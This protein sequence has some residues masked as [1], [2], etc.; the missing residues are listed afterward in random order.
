M[1]NNKFYLYCNKC[2]FEIDQFKD[3][4]RKNQ[5]CP[6]CN[7]EYVSVKYINSKFNKDYFKK[8]NYDL[9]Y[10][11]LW[12]Y[13]D[14]LP[15]N[16]KA[17]IISCGEGEVSIDRWSFLEEYARIHYGIRCKV[18]A[19]RQDNNFATGTFKDLAGS[20]V[21]SVLKENKIKNYITF[22]TG[23]IGV[24]YSRYLSEA[25]ISLYVFIPK[26]SSIAQEA[27][28]GCFGQKVFKVNGDYA[29]AKKLSK[30][31]ANKYNILISAGSF[32]PLRIE[33]KKTMVYEWK[34]KLSD[35]PTVYIQA[36]SGG[37]GPLGIHKGCKELKA[38]GIIN[39]SPR[40]ILV[41]SDK[42]SPMSDSWKSS[43]ESGFIS[44][45]E[46]KY[47]IIRNPKTM[48]TTLATGN[49][50]AYPILSR[51]VK[52][53]NGEIISFS[54]NKTTVIAQIVAFKVAVR[55]GPAAAVAV[56]GFFESLRNNLIKN[57]DIALIAIGEGIRRS[58]EFMSKLIYTTT[59][60]NDIDDCLLSDRNTLKRKLWSALEKL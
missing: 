34:R 40:F 27:E 20:V 18:Y 32:D 50:N 43:K 15:I 6:N 52:N 48:I 17:N 37:T 36:L 7:T 46:N 57:G 1:K 10:N 55:I 39:K 21:A 16:D 24:A 58:P 38:A 60:V 14:V 54:E 53:T 13:F 56:G 22:S 4:F 35:F 45:W 19:H 29:S 3:W 31:F 41:Q 51:I 42:C 26:D 23:N 30:I 33:A 49:P 9:Q 5:K 25:N 59:E 12:R 8:K 47:K 2:S 44:G 28:I 11:G